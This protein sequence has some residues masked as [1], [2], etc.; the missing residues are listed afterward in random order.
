MPQ[1]P[2]T[3]VIQCCFSSS[4]HSSLHQD[5]TAAPEPWLRGLTYFSS[6]SLY[7]CDSSLFPS[8]CPWVKSCFLKSTLL[9][10][11]PKII[12]KV[13]HRKGRWIMW[14]PSP[15]NSFIS[16]VLPHLG[17][18]LSVCCGT[19]HSHHT[20]DSRKSGKEFRFRQCNVNQAHSKAHMEQIKT[21]NS[22]LLLPKSLANKTT[23][24]IESCL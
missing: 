8:T 15:A 23:P 18:L 10:S 20:P 7:P 6:S 13:K 22:P 14:K 16:G 1:M 11:S 9:P 2:S 5:S 19:G 4:P 12:L 21:K 17:H 24:V 3:E